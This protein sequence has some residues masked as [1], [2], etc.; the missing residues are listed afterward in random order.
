MRNYNLSR[1]YNLK[2]LLLL[3]VNG[4]Y[5]IIFVRFI[6]IKKD[7]LMIR[8]SISLTFQLK[9]FTCF[10]ELL[11]QGRVFV[12]N[13]TFHDF[14]YIIK[15]MFEPFIIINLYLKGNNNLYLK[16]LNIRHIHPFEISFLSFFDYYGMTCEKTKL[17]EPHNFFMITYII[18]FNHKM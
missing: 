13:P 17:K 12:I 18:I 5:K 2:L 7:N 10:S 16:G 15:Y 11:L 1:T 3:F 8:K 14:I 9:V 4:F 6:T